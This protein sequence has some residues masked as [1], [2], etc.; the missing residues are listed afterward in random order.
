MLDRLE[1]IETRYEE[2]SNELS[3]AELLADRAA[4]TKATRQHRTLGE[5]VAKYR[6]WKTLN[7]ELSGARE[8]AENADDEEMREMARLEVESLQEQ[9]SATEDELKVLL[10]P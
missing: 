4:Y 10:I 8:L 2:L 9:L 7:E 6:S 3:S 1:Q 5:I